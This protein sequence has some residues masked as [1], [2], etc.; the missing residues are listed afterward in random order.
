L[1]ELVGGANNIIW[2]TDNPFRRNWPKGKDWRVM[3]LC[4]CPVDL[5]ATLANA[6]FT[7]TRGDDPFEWF[8]TK[9]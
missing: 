4:L 7:W 1:A 5:E 6:G 8:A 3:D 9:R 2:R